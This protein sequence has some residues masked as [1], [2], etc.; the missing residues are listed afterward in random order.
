MIANYKFQFLSTKLGCLADFAIH[1][2]KAHS[3]D[4]NINKN[5]TRSAVITTTADKFT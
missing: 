2:F 1:E 5:V 3:L 4:L